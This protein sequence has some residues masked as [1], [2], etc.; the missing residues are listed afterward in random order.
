MFKRILQIAI[1][2]TILFNQFTGHILD[3]GTN[4][5]KGEEYTYKLDDDGNAI[6]LQYNMVAA[7]TI[8]VPETVD[9]YSVSKIEGHCYDCSR[10]SEIQIP[11]I[12]VTICSEAFLNCED[13]AVLIVPDDLEIRKN[14]FQNLINLQEV[15]IIHHSGKMRDYP[16][17]NSSPWAASRN[18]LIAANI[19]DGVYYIGDY[20]FADT[21]ALANVHLPENLQ[22]IGSHAFYNSACVSNLTLTRSVLTLKEYAIANRDDEAFEMII[23]DSIRYFS[24]N[25]LPIY[26]SYICFADSPAEKYLSESGLEYVCYDPSFDEKLYSVKLAESYKFKV[27]DLPETIADLTSFESSDDIVCSVDDEGNLAALTTG[28]STV[29]VSSPYFQ[30]NTLVNVYLPDSQYET[31]YL[32]LKNGQSYQIVNTDFH[33]TEIQQEEV[34][35]SSFNNSVA[36]VTETGLIQ[37]G[38]PGTTYV[39]VA[40]M[41]GNIVQYMVKVTNS[42]TAINLN[43]T[44]IN[45]KI[46]ETFQL[47]ATVSPSNVENKKLRYESSDR[48]IATVTDTGLIKAVSSGTV[49]ITI[50]PAD[51]SEISREVTV[52]VT[53]DTITVNVMALPMMI[54]KKFQLTASS[55]SGKKLVYNSK[56]NSV[57]S[58][59]ENGCLYAHSAGEVVITISTYDGLSYR[60]IPVKVYS[61]AVAYGIDVSEWQG[62]ISLS[63]ME[64][65]K[66]YGID[67]I[68]IRAAYADSYEDPRFATNY[69]YA[70]S[71]GL[72]VGAYHY[73]EATTEQ[74]AIAEAKNMLSIISGKKFEYPV[75]LDIESSSHK[76]LSN[77]QFCAVV[78]AYCRTIQQG[79]YEVIVY[80]YASLLNKAGS[81]R[82]KYDFYIAH[83]DTTKSTVFRYDF[84]IWQFTS[85]GKL[86]VFRGRID[87]D[88]SFFDYPSYYK[89]NHLNGY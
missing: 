3:L 16:D 17:E 21:T 27:A 10:V 48:S 70:K 53:K 84:K 11:A 55:S 81:L 31:K 40:D 73:I 35:Y 66:K 74:E 79:G 51:G 15:N 26:G 29:S 63:M 62:Y 1:A 85:S 45:L 38:R 46:G 19:Q 71:V 25:S 72:D 60:S 20:C 36:S 59:D 34:L 14:A 44:S 22:T 8:S 32:S 77:A 65:I 88:I 80:S 61:G 78:D 89:R 4:W 39:R 33:L 30:Y 13:V 9:G 68:Y 18:M 28:Y 56:D 86:P 87:M 43:R 67:F 69:Q 37:A 54:G 47:K 23:P 6:L 83:W 42:I 7:D 12:S 64:Q 58:V 50:T 57:V 24:E 49:R 2:A 52:T 75:M 41:Q 5:K 76:T 82:D